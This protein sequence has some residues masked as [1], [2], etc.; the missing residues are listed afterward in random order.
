MKTKIAIAL[1][2]VLAA[3]LLSFADVASAAPAGNAAPSAIQ[4]A[5]THAVPAAQPLPP[6]PEIREALDSLRR[7]RRHIAEASHNFGGHKVEAL[8][9]TDA[10][11]AQLEICLKYE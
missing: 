8:R 6:H 3:L 5:A 2:T 7:A 10:A 1:V 9:A 11:I 4:P